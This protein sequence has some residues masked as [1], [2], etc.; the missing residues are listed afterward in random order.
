MNADSP[1]F[2]AIFM[3]LAFVVYGGWALFRSSKEYDAPIRASA[4][5][6]ADEAHPASGT[7]RS[8]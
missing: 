1:A 2:L 5:F 6:G 8:R 3:F 4:T 7:A